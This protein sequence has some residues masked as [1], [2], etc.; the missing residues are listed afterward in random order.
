MN[1]CVK[2]KVRK[3][4]EMTQVSTE[5]RIA[6]IQKPFE[7]VVGGGN[8]FPIPDLSSV[9]DTH[10][11][12]EDFCNDV[13]TNLDNLE[14]DL[15]SIKCV[16]SDLRYRIYWKMIRHQSPPITLEEALRDVVKNDNEKLRV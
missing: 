4:Q 2:H 15:E 3:E 8:K 14:N 5:D 7:V 1:N 9:E 13:T 16:V 10:I 6:A 12:D 11:T